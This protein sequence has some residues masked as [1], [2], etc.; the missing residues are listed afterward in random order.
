MAI[1]VG[2]VGVLLL[3]IILQDAFETVILPRRVTR[4]LRLTRLFYGYLW[5]LWSAL[6][7]RMRPGNR[8]ENYLS[9]FGP[10]SLPL[11]LGIWAVSL[12][13]S[14]AMLQW[15]LGSA[16]STPEGSVDFSFSTDLY[17]SGTT[18]F[19]LG[20]GDV[21]P[22]SALARLA[23]VI[24]A[25][26]GLAFLALVIGYLPVIYQAFSRREASTLLLDAR[27][28]SPPSAAELLRRNNRCD[29]ADALVQLMHDW[30]R[31]SAELLESHI[32]Y[33]VLCYYRS[34]H[35]SQSWLAAL[36]AIMDTCAL[37]SIGVDS[38]P[39][40][41]ARL[42]FAMA[43]HAAVDLSQIFGTPPRPP[44]IDR[45]PPVE[46][47]R[48]RALLAE[49]GVQLREGDAAEQKLVEIRKKYEPYVNA[50]AEYLLMPL[51]PWLP[52]ADAADDWQTS[53][54]EHSATAP[55]M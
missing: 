8:R 53:V 26:T 27:A 18:L 30:E 54:W 49:A 50:L 52:I 2:V 24:E 10:I 28:G 3:L 7:R 31:W 46:L 37:V 43:R 20:L 44:Q 5:I 16:M 38:T 36:T 15:A 23:T 14:F 35:D 4:R 11:L 12:I 9:Y 51:P 19:T 32:S 33:P 1:F 47:A 13:V 22:V 34:Q 55:L 21:R 29:T 39:I 17:E 48:L 6:A 40:W 25:G 41:P 45:L 42:T